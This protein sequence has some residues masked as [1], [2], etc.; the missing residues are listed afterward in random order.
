MKDASA[1]KKIG[2]ALIFERLWKDLGIGKII[3]WLLADRKFEF[4]AEHDGC[5]NARSGDPRAAEPVQHIENLYRF[6]PSDD[7]R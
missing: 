2:P 1:A 3:R 5:E 6:R 7:Q 4:D